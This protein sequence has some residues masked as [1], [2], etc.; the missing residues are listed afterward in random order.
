MLY[1]DPDVKATAQC[2]PPIDQV[3]RVCVDDIGVP[4]LTYAVFG[5]TECEPGT[6]GACL[7]CKIDAAG[8]QITFLL[9]HNSY[10]ETAA[11]EWERQVFI[12]NFRSFNYALDNGYHTELDGPEEGLE[13]NM[14]L[15]E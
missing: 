9:Q 15:V 7:A 2:I 6:D 12:R 5:K 3:E 10:S 14:Q 1:D 4:V 8:M 11:S 13:Y